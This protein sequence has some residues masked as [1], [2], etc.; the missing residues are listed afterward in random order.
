MIYVVEVIQNNPETVVKYV[1]DFPSIVY[2]IIKLTGYKK[3]VIASTDD[4]G[5]ISTY[6]KCI[7]DGY[8]IY[9]ID[10]PY[11]E[12]SCWGYNL[13]F[14]NASWDD[15]E[16]N[17]HVKQ[18]GEVVI[19]LP[20]SR[21]L[22]S[23]SMGLPYRRRKGEYKTVLHWGQRKLMMSEIEFLTLGCGSSSSESYDWRVIYCG[24]SPGLHIPF[25]SKLF[26]LVIFELYDPTEFQIEETEK[27]RLHNEFFTDDT[28]RQY[29]GKNVLFIS[30]IRNIEMSDHFQNKNLVEDL[31]KKDMDHQKKWVKII[32]PSL[33]MLKFRLPWEDGMTRYLKGKIHRPV[34]GPQTTTESRLICEGNYEE[35]EYDNRL[36]ESQMFYHNTVTRVACYQHLPELGITTIPGEGFD[37]CFDCT[38]EIRILNE[39]INKFGV[40]KFVSEEITDDLRCKCIALMS[41]SISLVLGNRKLCSP[42][43]PPPRTK[44]YY[45]DE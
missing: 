36:Y 11:T 26:P 18:R 32:R 9:I 12:D 44:K 10:H 34:W 42:Q 24:A 37:H 33:A 5:T 28:A 6:D 19:S 1:N 40:S 35:M 45:D 20:F 2:S 25:L 21:V 8:Y 31:V 41:K 38:S 3:F 17:P 4:L 15:I 39:Y 16:N 22:T 14:S 13:I 29:A 30:D 7:K 43:P 23:S 27:I